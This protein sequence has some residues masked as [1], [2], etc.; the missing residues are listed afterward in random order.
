MIHFYI[1]EAS[2]IVYTLYKDP[3]K[4]RQ[5]KKIFDQNI[6]LHEVF[7][8]AVPTTLIITVIW[9]EALGKTR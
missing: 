7:L 4:G 1:S 3:A 6:G 5:I 9:V 2:R 8:E